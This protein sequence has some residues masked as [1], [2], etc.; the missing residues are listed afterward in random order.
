[1]RYSGPM[2][3]PIEPPRRTT[4]PEVKSAVLLKIL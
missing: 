3:Y 4:L 2:V 1:M